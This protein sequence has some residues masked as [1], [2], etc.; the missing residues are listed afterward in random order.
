MSLEDLVKPFEKIDVEMETLELKLRKVDMLQRKSGG[1][2][3][4]RSSAR[5]VS[6]EAVMQLREIQ[7]KSRH[8]AK[9]ALHNEVHMY[10]IQIQICF[11][12]NSLNC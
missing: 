3:E 2:E 11:D 5:T 7:S 4:N 8:F 1:N 12:E 9:S 10:K 6:I